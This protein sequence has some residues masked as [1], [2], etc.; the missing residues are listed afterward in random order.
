MRLGDLAKGLLRGRFCADL[1]AGERMRRLVRALQGYLVLV[2]IGV[3]DGRIL[4][5][6]VRDEGLFVGYGLLGVLRLQQILFDCA[7]QTQPHIFLHVYHLE[8]V[9]VQS[10]CIPYN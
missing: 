6:V 8:C 4:H 10:V 5:E 9:C 1:A 2:R 3:L 7:L